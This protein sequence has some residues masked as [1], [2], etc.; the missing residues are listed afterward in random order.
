[1][2]VDARDVS[3]NNGEITPEQYAALLSERGQEK[4]SGFMETV[5]FEGRIETQAGFALNKDYFLG[6]VVEVINEYGIAAAPRIIE[7]I[8][9][10]DNT[11]RT[12]IPAFSTWEV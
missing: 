3:S 9:C 7:I 12:V 5:N 8:D 11:G 1:M 4:L 6:D 2:F 10:D